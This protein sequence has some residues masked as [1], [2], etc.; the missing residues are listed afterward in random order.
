MYLICIQLSIAIMND[1][2]ELQRTYPWWNRPLWGEQ[3][4]VDWVRNRS[5][6]I[7]KEEIPEARIQF[8]Q[9][10]HKQLKTIAAM[11]K[12]IDNAK[13]NADNL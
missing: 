4:F 11:T 5:V 10:S 2:N 12:A 8:Y 3:S 6:L 13:F 7:V 9:D 1:N